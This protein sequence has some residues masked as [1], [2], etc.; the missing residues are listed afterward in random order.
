MLFVG[1]VSVHSAYVCGVGVCVCVCVCG[2]GSWGGGLG[3]EVGRRMQVGAPRRHSALMAC[4]PH[5]CLHVPLGC[6]TVPC[7]R[8]P[9]QE[10][11]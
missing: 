7:G 11:T 9:R 10:V 2:N 1:T 4:M 8:Q 6:S 5:L 3:P